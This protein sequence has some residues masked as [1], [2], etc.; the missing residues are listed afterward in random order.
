MLA[1]QQIVNLFDVRFI[2]FIRPQL[3]YADAVH[4]LS[5]F[6]VF[7]IG[8][9]V[10]VEKKPAAVLQQLVDKNAKP[11]MVQFLAPSMK[12]KS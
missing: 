5:A 2:T 8:K 3:A 1:H 12:Q 10:I 11:S 9:T 7:S 6:Q 4:Y